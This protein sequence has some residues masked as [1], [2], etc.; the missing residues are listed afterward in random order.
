MQL[1][2]I[3]SACITLTTNKSKPPQQNIYI[4]LLSNTFKPFQLVFMSECQ[5]K[6]VNDGPPN[7][8]A[9]FQNA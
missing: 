9:S 4:L 1:I 7:T 2:T 5:T 6:A 3:V 8:L